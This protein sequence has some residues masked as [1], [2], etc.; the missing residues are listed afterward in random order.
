MNCFRDD[1]HEAA[2]RC[3]MA[4]QQGSREA[5]ETMPNGDQFRARRTGPDV[6][7]LSFTRSGHPNRVD[8]SDQ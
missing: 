2:V 4:V 5:T 1:E 6:I 8:W 3:V 7:A